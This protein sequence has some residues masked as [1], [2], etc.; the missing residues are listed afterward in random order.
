M[1]NK[2]TVIAVISDMQVGSTV[3]LCPPKWNLLDGGTHIA[4]PAQM[5]IYRQWIHS[6]KKVNE[7]LHEG[8]GRKRLVLILNGEPIDNYHHGTPQIITKRPQ[9][10]I[11]M[12]IALLDEWMQ[13]AEYEP[14]HG[15]K[16]YLVRG[17]SAHENGEYINQIGRD[18]DGVVPYRKDTSSITKDGRYYFHKLRRTVNGKL[19]HIA[20]HGF[21]RGSRAHT[22]SNSLR[23]TLASMYFDALDYGLPIPDY[24]VRSHNH[25]YTYDTYT[26]ERKTIWGCITPCW[27][28]KTHFGNQVAANEDINTIGM[29]Y[30]DV[31]KSGYSMPYAE[32]IK[33]EDTPIKEF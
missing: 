3:A 28:L 11:D 29:V 33:V 25:V 2:D 24:V 8:R 21:T 12:A 4:S 31:L 19:F 15:D 32:Y 16:M 6:A 5:I 23:Y 30:F 27:Q 1:P 14:K 7:L 17:T 9:E 13:I 26:G 20:H 10:Q 18:L 22:R